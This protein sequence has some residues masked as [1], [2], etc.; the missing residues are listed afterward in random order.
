[1]PLIK[2]GAL[3]GDP[4]A[5]VAD[6]DA[7]PDGP[8]IVSLKRFLAERD[9]LLARNQK[10]GVVL[11]SDT[12]PE[13]LAGD[14]E[15]LAVVVLE[16][17]KFRD[18]RVFSWARQ[19]RTRYGFTNEIRVRGDY[20]YDQIAFLARVGVDAFELPPSLTPE[21]F[22]RALDEMTYVYQPS[23]DGKATILDL[24]R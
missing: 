4:F 1:M 11:A 23:A 22:A 8:A 17:P 21:L 19:L 20:L 7:L 6:A 5:T 18:G 13:V 10:L 15:R 16:F 24:R 3:A 2:N 14:L 12:S 9:A